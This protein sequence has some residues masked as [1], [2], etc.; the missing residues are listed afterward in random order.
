VIDS[1]EIG[2]PE[3][4]ESAFR[5]PVILGVL[6]VTRD[7]F[8]DG[9]Q[10]LAT[11]AAVAHA[12]ELVKGGAHVIDIGAA[13][14]NPNAEYV[15]P[16]EEISRI[17]PVLQMLKREG[18]PASID[19]FSPEVQKWAIAQDVDYLN[20]IHGFPDPGLYPALA[21]SGA[22]LIVMHAVQER[23]RATSVDVPVEAIVRRIVEF[24][25][26]RVRALERAG[27]KRS[28]LIL[29]PGMGFFLSSRAEVSFEVLRRL[30]ALKAAF[31]LPMLIS[32]SRKSFLRRTVKRGASDVG[33]ATLAA[34]I[35]AVFRGADYIRTHDPAALADGL[36]VW[37]AAL[38]CNRTSG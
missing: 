3:G 5:L 2:T 29:D 34:E 15:P 9:G 23:G 4:A 36:A 1:P 7:S 12:R 18:I 33:F 35:F 21:D 27:V 25:D 11:D 6:N 13:A 8:S 32:V 10:F 31:G 37:D 30:P 19:T 24:F 38:T 17:A 14:S 28:R 26:V 22:K 16:Q 20:D